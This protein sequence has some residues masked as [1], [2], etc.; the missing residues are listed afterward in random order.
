M[1]RLPNGDWLVQL[2]GNEV[3]VFKEGSEEEV[4]RYDNRT[5]D[6]VAVA[7]KVIYDSALLTP[8]QKC[9]AHFWCGYFHAFI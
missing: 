1:A 2:I 3:I 4:V 8:E 7:Q 5:P 9:F 6:A